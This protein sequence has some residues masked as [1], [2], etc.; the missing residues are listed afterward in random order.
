MSEPRLLHRKKERTRCA[1]LSAA[2]MLFYEGSD[3]DKISIQHI[4][5][6]A[7][8]GLGTFYNYFESKQVFF[9]AVLDEIRASFN[10]RLTELRVPLKDPAT[11]V[12]V[13]LRYCFQQAQD[14]DEWLNFLSYS[15]ISG[16]HFLH[17]DDDQCLADIK[18]GAESGRFQVDD[19]HFTC[20]LVMG[21]VRH[22]TSEIFKGNLNRDA[23]SETTRHV[24]RMLGIPDLVAKALTQVPLPPVAAPRRPVIA[25]RPERVA[26]KKPEPVTIQ[27]QAPEPA[28]AHK[29]IATEKPG[30][31]ATPGSD[32]V[33]DY[34]PIQIAGS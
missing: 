9:E 27:A 11:I 7:N 12:A 3:E 8:V 1:L 30:S 19:V 20:S 16:E 4:T 21:M 17:Q 33:R 28:T 34:Q 6:R 24:L 5:D 32:P 10:E 18:W 22:V 15:G 25:P 13:T 26:A 2:R 29:S 23:M 14:N 31:V